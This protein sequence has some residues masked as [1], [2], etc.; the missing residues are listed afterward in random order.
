MP[1]TRFMASLRRVSPPRRHPG[2]ALAFA[3]V[4]ACGEPDV[5]PPD[6]SALPP[7]PEAVTVADATRGAERPIRELAIALVG[8][9][10]AEI[11]PCGC[12]TLPYG[13]FARREA[14]LTELRS[15]AR[16]L[17][18]LDAGELLLKGADDDPRGGEE[19]PRG[20]PPGAVGRCRRG[21]LGAR[22]LGPAGPGRGG[23]GRPAQRR[24]GRA[25]CGLGDLGGRVGRPAPALAVVEAGDLRVGVIGMSAPPQGREVRDLV[26]ARP[27][28]R[29]CPE[30]PGGP[31]GGP[32][33]GGRAGGA[34]RHGGRGA[35]GRG[36]RARPGV[37]HPG[38]G[39]PA[40]PGGWCGP[41]DRR[42]A[43]PGAAPAGGGAPAGHRSGRAAAGAPAG[44]RVATAADRAPPGGPGAEA[45]SPELAE[46]QAR[47]DGLEEAFSEAARGGT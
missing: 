22:P 40:A 27:L 31:A 5:P 43:R 35:R 41:A 12:P 30:R 47:L 44:R 21:R 15:S 25:A 14:L 7:L 29:G 26:R 6:L 4:A 42:D 13:G 2:F 3:V 20:A 11:E 33:P 8:E 28:A 46:R 18:H 34:G 16:P 1:T 10:R 24:A 39:G 36:A 23:A 17:L 37:D 9:V 19:A 32:R 45:G 38:H